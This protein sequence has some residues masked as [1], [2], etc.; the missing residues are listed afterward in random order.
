MLADLDGDGLEEI[1]VGSWDGYLYM[2]KDDRQHE[3]VARKQLDGQLTV[4]AVYTA[5]SFS[6]V[7]EASAP[8]IAFPGPTSTRAKMYYKA[9]LKGDD[10]PANPPGPGKK[11]VIHPVPLVV[12]RGQLTGLVQPFPA[13][14]KVNYWL[15]GED[16]RQMAMNT[17]HFNVV[18]DWPGRLR[19]RLRRR[20]VTQ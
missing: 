5:G 10:R 2:V 13:G 6:S 1:V 18:R 17:Y 20:R 7:R 15:E 3:Q 11:S 12:H 16:E 8:F 19:R 4:P 9:G 14:M